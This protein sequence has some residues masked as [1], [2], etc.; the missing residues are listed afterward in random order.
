MRHSEFNA[1]KTAPVHFLQIWII[2]ERKGLKPSY[3]QKTFTGPDKAGK[4]L[5]VGSRGG[6]N[7]SVTIQQDVD[8]YATVLEP[9]ESVSHVLAADRVAWVQVALGAIKL[10]GNVLQ[11]G[12][13]MAVENEGKLRLEGQSSAE[14]LL[15]DMIP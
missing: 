1:S 6:R 5:L 10:N 11:A 12:D 3:E 4:L 14:V 13:G 7:G 8:L 15:F 9:G 2:P